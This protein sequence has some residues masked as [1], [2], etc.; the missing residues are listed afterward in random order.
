MKRMMLAALLT[1]QTVGLPATAGPQ[2][3]P[4]SPPRATQSVNDALIHRAISETLAETP[5]PL[6]VPTQSNATFSAGSSEKILARAFMQ[7]KVPDCLHTDA[8]K[9]APA[10]I[11]AVEFKEVAAAPFWAYA[12]VSGKCH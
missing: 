11:G 3:L 8:M 10:K 4:P 12:I 7:A 6:T 1:L 9:L 5:V 2:P